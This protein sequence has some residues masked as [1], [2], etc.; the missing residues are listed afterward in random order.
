MDDI[1]RRADVGVGT[2]YRH[3]P[4][5]EALITELGRH[6]MQDRIAELDAAL[7]ADDPWARVGHRA[8]A[9]RPGD[10]P[11]T[12]GCA[13]SSA[14]VGTAGWCPGEVADC[15]TRQAEL[16]RRLKAAGQ[17]RADVTVN[18]VQAMMCGLAAAIEGGGKWRLHVDM[19][20]AGLRPPADGQ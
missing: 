6:K 5:K 14:S 19:M 15:R 11:A 12:P 10:G 16:L 7:A 2:L 20:L 9:R 3:F 17:V 13:R 18:D 1:A 4:T 8:A